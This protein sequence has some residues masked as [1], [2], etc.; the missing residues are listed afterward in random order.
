MKLLD[1]VRNGY[2]DRTMK[3]YDTAFPEDE[4]KDWQLMLNKRREGV[5]TIEAIVSDD[6]G[7]L[8]E[9]ICLTTGDILLIDYLAVA[10]DCR[11]MGVGSEVLKL[12][13]ADNPG[14]RLILEIE[15]TLVDAL[16]TEQRKR[17]KNFYLRSGMTP[18]KW[19]VDLF[20][21]EMEILTLGGRVSFDEYKELLT[22][23]YG[24]KFGEN[25]ILLI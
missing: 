8:G 9:V 20:G 23:V 12:L 21:V 1:A 6:G 3:L 5:M 24:E 15:S 19:R 4:K 17:R 7:F 10:P 14:K 13:A 16:N 22:G 11:G 18:E 25:V 2:L